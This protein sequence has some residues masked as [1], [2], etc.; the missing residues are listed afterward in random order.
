[1][2]A[3]VVEDD[4]ILRST[5]TEILCIEGF[6]VIAAESVGRAL[7][8]LSRELS[9]VVTD[10]HL[11]DRSGCEIVRA[12]QAL[13]V[14]TVLVTGEAAREDIAR[15]V[16]LGARFVVVKPFC[17]RELVRLIREATTERCTLWR[18]KQLAK[19]L[20]SLFLFGVGLSSCIAL[21]TLFL[22][23]LSKCLHARQ[24]GR[25]LL[26]PKFRDRGDDLGEDRPVLRGRSR[27]NRNDV[28]RPG[29]SG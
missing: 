21:G 17:R 14:P 10:Y 15:A 20:L 8:A 2:K 28:R 16:N 29:E 7:K 9:V 3:L 27:G 18:A 1:M 22:E 11:P 13:G 19:R 26:V 24:H 5:L 25:D 4:E 12:A 6:E 23:R